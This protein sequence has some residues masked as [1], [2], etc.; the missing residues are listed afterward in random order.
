M[1]QSL[2]STAISHP[3][4]VTTIYRVAVKVGEDFYTLESAITLPPDAT[5]E[6][7][8]Q[9]VATR[10]AIHAAQ[11]P[12]VNAIVAALKDAA[13]EPASPEQR[14]F[15]YRLLPQV[16]WQEA[17]LVAYLDEHGQTPETLT[18]RQA[19][20]LIDYLK[21]IKDGSVDNPVQL[22]DTNGMQF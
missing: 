19:S 20:K 5:P 4:G 13:G 14:G 1:T 8:D 9:A 11:A 17:D 6:Q 21:R 3:N 12:G 18:K 22:V 2:P 7:I 16:G 15:I 10:D